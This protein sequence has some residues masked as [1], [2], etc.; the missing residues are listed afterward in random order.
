M[1]STCDE[2][3]NVYNIRERKQNK[4]STNQDDQFDTYKVPANLVLR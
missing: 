2:K 3:P 4:R 1:Q